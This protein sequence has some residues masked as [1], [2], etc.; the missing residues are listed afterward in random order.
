[1][2]KRLSLSVVVPNA[3]QPRKFFDA[4]E[5]SDLADSIAANGLQQPITVRPLPA[6]NFEIVMGER[7][8]RAH[9]LLEKTGRLPAGSILAHV[10]R[11]DDQQRDIEAIVENMQRKDI[12]PLEEARAFQRMICGGMTVEELATRVGRHTHRIEERTRL[13][14][15]E[16]SLMTLY[17]GGQLSQEAASE[18]SRLT[19]PAM[20]TKIARLI[21]SGQIVGF[22]SIR[23][24]VDAALGLVDQQ[25][26]FGDMP[27]APLEKDVATVTGMEKRVDVIIG[28][29]NQ[30]WKDG[31]CVIAT[32]VDANR[33]RL[34]ADKLETIQKMLRIMTRDL[35]SV[36]AQ[37]D[38][39]LQAAE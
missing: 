12:T 34:M 26:L 35:R 11:M 5:I 21:N 25:A 3:D 4:K 7:R 1:M 10:R 31:E 20:Q 19:N 18:I 2:M 6:G 8:F 33:A 28:M 14:N 36:A 9:Q 32:K 17:E 30:G 13:L 16:A 27:D 39:L 24:A 23:S 22:K 37:G 15:L 38:I 29:V